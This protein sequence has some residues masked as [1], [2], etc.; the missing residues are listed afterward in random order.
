M[1]QRAHETYR[2]S[3]LRATILPWFTWLFTTFA[4][5][6]VF[7]VAGTAERTRDS[8]KRETTPPIA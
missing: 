2:S 1:V 7:S 6:A 3:V 8:E 4:A 5:I